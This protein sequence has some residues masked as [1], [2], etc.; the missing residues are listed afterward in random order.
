MEARQ[1]MQIAFQLMMGIS[2][3]ACAGLR[4]W[5][6]LLGV[7]LLARTGHVPLNPAFAFLARTDL[8]IVLGVAT[9]IELLGDKFL[10]VDH[11]LD[12]VGTVARPV[13]GTLLAASV[14]THADPVVSTV[15]GLILGGSTAFTIHAGKAAVRT[16]ST[17]LAPLHAG[18]GNAAL[19]LGEDAISLG[20]IGLAV[21]VPVLAFLLTVC[22]LIAC[23]LLIRAAWHHGRRLFFGTDTNGG[24]VV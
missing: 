20:G 7:G 4:A 15:L 22:A 12:L 9:A 8:L 11:F 17:A 10:I 13:A 14:L 21:W 2:L 1:T 5:L 3:A 18:T 23:V 24:G 19:S 6:P 16:Q